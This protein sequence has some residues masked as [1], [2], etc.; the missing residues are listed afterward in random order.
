VLCLGLFGCGASNSESA[1]P[2]E[3]GS[4]SNSKKIA[5]KVAT[6]HTEDY[7]ST[8]AL[9]KFKEDLEAASNNMFEVTVYPNSQLGTET[10]IVSHCSCTVQSATAVHCG[11][12]ES[13]FES[14]DLPFLFEDYDHVERVVTSDVFNSICDPFTQ[15]GIRAVGAY[16]NGLRVIST[17]NKKIESL[18]DLKGLKMRVP[19]APMSI[20]IFSALG[21]NATPINF[22]ELYAA[23]QQGVVDGQENGYPT[24]DSNK[25]YEV[26]KYIA[27]TYHMWGSNILFVSEK[28]FQ[29][30]TAEQQEMV[31]KCL[32]DSCTTQRKLYVESQDACKQHLMEKGI[33][34]TYP[35]MQAFRDATESCYDNFYKDYPDLK[36]V[37]EEIIAMRDN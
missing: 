24:I 6:Q 7:P 12:N 8:V 33:E 26:Q 36:P 22:S 31:L 4:P 18:E 15:F 20:A 1:T 9:L 5:I 28:F 23:L 32:E 14:F 34:I 17:T 37:V 25:Y 29:S 13:Q 10:D 27:E 30:L 19:E 11:Y 35:D 2:N 3:E 16:H 21:C